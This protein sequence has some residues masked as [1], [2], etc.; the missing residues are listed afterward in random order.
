VLPFGWLN[1][2]VYYCVLSYQYSKTLWF[3]GTCTQKLKK[4][5]KFSGYSTGTSKRPTIRI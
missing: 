2:N 3:F 5:I 4:K 1:H